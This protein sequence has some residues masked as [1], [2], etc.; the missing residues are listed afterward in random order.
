M[1]Y[2]IVSREARRRAERS[3]ADREHARREAEANPRRPWV[4]EPDAKRRDR[5]EARQFLPPNGAE[6]VHGSIDFQPV[7]FLSEGTR[8][9]RAV[10]LVTTS[11]EGGS[12]FMI[13]K[14]LFITNHHVIHDRDEAREATIAF[15]YQLDEDNR[16]ISSTRFS[17]DPDTCF[18]TAKETDLD[19]TIVA[20]GKPQTDGGAKVFGYCVLSD[21]DDKH[22]IGMPVNIIQHPR[23]LP[24]IVVLRNNILTK[25][26]ERVL[27]YETDT[28]VGSSGSPVFNDGWDVVALHHWGEPFLERADSR[29]RKLAATVNEGV[30][31][32]RI[33][34]RIRSQLPRL[35]PRARA[36][37]EEALALGDN[38]RIPED[39]VPVLHIAA[40]SRPEAMMWNP[41]ATAMA[42]ETF[43]LTIPLEITLKIGSPNSTG[44][45]A[46]IV[47][48]ATPVVDGAAPVLALANGNGHAAAARTA[49][50]GVKIDTN[51]A[52]R[53]GYDPAFLDGHT[54]ALP[55][56]KKASVLAPLK[57]GG[58]EL[59]YEHYSV[60]IHKDRRMA[61]FTATNVDGKSYL[62]ILRK[63]GAPS[64]PEATDVWY[65]DPRIDA[66]YF[67]GADFYAATSTYFDKGHLT[68]REDPTWG[69]ASVAVRANAD[70]FHYTNCTPQNWFFNES[71]TIWQGIEQFVLEKGAVP[72]K[73]K[74]CVFQGPI[75]DDN[76]AK[77]A[78][79][80]VPL[81]FWKLVVW[82]GKAGLRAAAFKASQQDVIQHKRGDRPKT[83]KG[84]DYIKT[85]RVPVKTI[86]A[87]TGLDFGE[88]AKHDT[89]RDKIGEGIQL[90]KNLKDIAL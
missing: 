65:G 45:T 11:G 5:F 39:D 27:L 53:K 72:T 62:K 69:P 85:Y 32:S 77:M 50:E 54:I 29:G 3:K 38:A 86:A 68:R 13:S 14:R 6:S 47:I 49:D 46:P 61:L 40:P 48:S 87:A 63:T 41:G 75:L 16:P 15:D 78:E 31:I 56:P 60:K 88:L 58:D 19:F 82:V 79:V 55:K 20:L 30:R 28:D 74:L 44:T 10:A 22:A 42:P 90:I 35:E 33:V 67:I 23:L 24:K 76:Y 52:N 25:R 81:E 4:A 70:T 57:A 7:A 34:Q 21:R 51:Y 80:L 17:L 43:K 9:S 12:G 71:T 84:K 89:V 1:T 66:R 2:D 26:L 37:L 8:V 64:K 36:L 18:V 73:N 59:K 83:V